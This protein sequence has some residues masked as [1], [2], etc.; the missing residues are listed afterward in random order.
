VV[1]TLSGVADFS[2]CFEKARNILS[3]LEASAAM[4]AGADFLVS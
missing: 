4:D 1:I 3:R 2:F